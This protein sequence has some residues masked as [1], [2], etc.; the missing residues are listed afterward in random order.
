MK[1][2]IDQSGVTE[3]VNILLKEKGITQTKLQGL[4]NINNISR[5]MDSEKT[6]FSWTINDINKI[7]ESLYVNKVWLMTGEGEMMTIDLVPLIAE[8]IEQW[9]ETKNGNVFYRKNNGK[10][11][12]ESKVLPI[13]A[14]GSPEDEFATILED[15][16]FEKVFWDVNEVHHGNYYTFRVKGDSMDDGS[17]KSFAEGDII[18]VRELP[19]DE[20]LPKLRIKDWP[21]WVVCWDNNVRIKQIISQDEI[22]GDITLH[23][24]NPSPEY[25]DFTLK[26]DQISKLCNVV[27]HRHDNS[28]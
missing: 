19:K 12:M 20:W 15:G 17:R 26:L 21:Y 25:T 22:T 23:S 9:Y 27:K 4:A 14:L 7:C 16:D 11:V 1:N 2:E 3:R 28:F 5:K 10:L 13:A 24:L 18:L 6:Q 8:P